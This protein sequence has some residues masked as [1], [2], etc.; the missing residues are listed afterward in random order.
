MAA[1]SSGFGFGS[2][3]RHALT[4]KVSGVRS[5]RLIYGTAWKKENTKSL[6]KLALSN[7]F[8]GIDTACQPKHYNEAGVGEALEEAFREKL[9]M[10]SDVFLQTKFTPLF[11]QDESQPLPYDK[12]APLAEQVA[13]SV[14]T[15]LANLRV[16]SID[17]LVLHAPLRTFEESCEVWQAMQEWTRK[18]NDAGVPIVRQIGIS[19]VYSF[20]A[21]KQ[22]W[23]FAD[24]K[25][26]VVQ[27]RFIKRFGFDAEI[28]QFCQQKGIKYQGFSLLTANP[29]IVSSGAVAAAAE[30]RS[31]TPEAAFFLFA[32]SLGDFFTPL[33]GSTSAHHQL[34]DLR[35]LDAAPLSQKEIEAIE[36]E[37]A[38][39]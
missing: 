27:N 26:A 24:V 12:N 30:R 16:E 37:M 35:A 25:P 19:N 14:K 9:V 38:R 11:G 1:A 18:T 6:V 8:R 29:R 36:A 28:R 13:Q 7:G 5:P 32:F 17:S 4:S 2:G 10:R 22:L 33:T 34:H 39:V 31:I 23:E 15:S 3:G 20:D 21:L